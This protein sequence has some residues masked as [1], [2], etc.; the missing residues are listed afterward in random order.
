SLDLLE[1]ES[2]KQLLG[3]YVRSAL[4]MAMLNAVEP[5]RDRLAL[6]SI[7]SDNAEALRYLESTY[8]PRPAS[9]GAAIRVRFDA[10]PDITDA[11]RIVRIEGAVLEPLQ[12]FELTQIL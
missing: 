8:E 12:I 2:L 6:E 11:A 7:Q 1:F 5:L 4:G 10:L 3:R 9:R